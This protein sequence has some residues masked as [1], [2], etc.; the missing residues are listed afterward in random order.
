M[1]TLQAFEKKTPFAVA[2]F[3]LF[4]TAL[5]VAV[6]CLF[7]AGSAWAG[8]E[9]TYDLTAFKGTENALV[10]PK[11]ANSHQLDMSNRSYVYPLADSD[12]V[13]AVKSSNP[14]V[15]KAALRTDN[16]KR[17]VVQLKKPGTATV[18]FKLNGKKRSMTYK[19]AKY[20]NPV[21]V[22]KIGKLNLTSKFKESSVYSWYTDG[23]IEKQPNPKPITGRINIKPAKGWKLDKVFLFEDLAG[24]PLKQVKNGYVMTKADGKRCH[25]VHAVLQSKKTGIRVAVRYETAEC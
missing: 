13:A 3:A 21:S 5:V 18:S 6:C 1:N 8:Q 11:R 22:F 14:K 25:V 4:S 9:V 17:I 12:K 7:S 10:Y 2:T 19:V 23:P 15:V 20:Q 24:S 16:Y